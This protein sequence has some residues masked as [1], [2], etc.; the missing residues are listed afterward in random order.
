LSADSNVVELLGSNISSSHRSLDV[1]DESVAV[2]SQ[3]V[4][5]ICRKKRKGLMSKVVRFGTTR[6]QRLTFVQRIVCVRLQEK[7]LNTDHDCVEVEYR[8]PIFSQNVEADVS[9][10]IQIGV[11]DL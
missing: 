3:I 11:V 2:R 5:G 8:F 4:C 7:I 6:A 10:Q 9:R 1:L